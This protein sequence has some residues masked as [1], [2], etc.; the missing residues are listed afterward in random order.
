[1]DI[2]QAVTPLAADSTHAVFILVRNNVF[3][4]LKKFD[5]KALPLIG[6]FLEYESDSKV[7][8]SDSVFKMSVTTFFNAFKVVPLQLKP[9]LHL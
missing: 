4:G 3:K 5:W 6:S 9:C 7:S 2:L 1:M 8:K